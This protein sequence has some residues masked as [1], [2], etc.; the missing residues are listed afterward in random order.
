MNAFLDCTC[1]GFDCLVK[2][3]ADGVAYAACLIAYACASA[4]DGG[5]RMQT[6]EKTW[7]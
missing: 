4:I 5:L 2:G 1:G 3:C 6:A 7:Q